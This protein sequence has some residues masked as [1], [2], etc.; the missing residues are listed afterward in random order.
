MALVPAYCERCKI[1]FTPNAIFI[2]NSFDI[3]I[4]GGT[5]NC[6]RCGGDAK[7]VEGRFNERGNGLE[8]ISA[9]AITH[10][11]LAAIQG[12]L[13]RTRSGELSDEEALEE[14][15]AAAP[16]LARILRKHFD[17]GVAIIAL[18][19]AIAGLLNQCAGSEADAQYQR[20]VI[21]LLDRQ[22]QVMESSDRVGSNKDSANQS[23]TGN[24]QNLAPE[25]Q[26]SRTTAKS[27]RRKVVNK[28]R[29]D[30]LL[31]RRSEFN[32]RPK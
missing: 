15:I 18:L 4:G 26:K 10:T 5:T 2:E 7:L 9:P 8:I 16:F 17:R 22:L 6:P 25:K 27:D 3:K 24:T 31:K 32:P 20:Q 23:H 21:D 1:A 19:V 13:E 11:V 28:T 12:V 29:R 14:A 30:E